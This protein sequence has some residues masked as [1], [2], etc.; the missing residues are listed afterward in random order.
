MIEV[1]EREPW[2]VPTKWSVKRSSLALLEVLVTKIKPY[3]T[4]FIQ[5]TFE[6]FGFKDT[7]L[8]DFFKRFVDVAIW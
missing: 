5:E 1:S 2:G 4:V 3:G 8:L 6:E 7:A